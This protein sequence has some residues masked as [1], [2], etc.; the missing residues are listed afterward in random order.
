MGLLDF[1]ISNEKGKKKGM[2]NFY[3]C[4]EDCEDCMHRNE[5]SDN[6]E[7]TWDKD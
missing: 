3:D 7:F 2:E 6:D 5:C 1:L 4:P